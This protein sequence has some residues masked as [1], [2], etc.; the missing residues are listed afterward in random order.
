MDQPPLEPRDDRR[1]PEGRGPAWSLIVLPAVWL[2]LGVAGGYVIIETVRDDEAPAQS[3]QRTSKGPTPTAKATAKKTAEPKP[4][5]SAKPK[6]EPTTEPTTQATAEP[7]ATRSI[8]VSVYNQIGIGGLAARVAGQ[9]RA[10]G[11]TIGAVAD[12]R[13]S[14]PQDTIYYPAGRQ[15]EAALLG[16]DLGISRLMPATAGMSGTNLTV[17]LAS[18]R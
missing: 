17:V 5:K 8:G 9:A 1:D 14:V 15:G 4:K 11:W 13:G 6:T 3:A 10:A 12:W 18:P 7:T 2:I 16:R